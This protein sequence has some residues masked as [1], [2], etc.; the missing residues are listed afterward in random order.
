[1]F[2]YA[3]SNKSIYTKY[4][5]YIN[6]LF[7]V[8]N[9]SSIIPI[10]TLLDYELKINQINDESFIKNKFEKYLEKHFTF[11]YLHFNIFSYPTRDFTPSMYKVSLAIND[12]YNKHPQDPKNQNN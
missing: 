6:C 4:I 12:A 3:N 2:P 7:E 11:C 10:L 9:K 8:N 1:M 5:N